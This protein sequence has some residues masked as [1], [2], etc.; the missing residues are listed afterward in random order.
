MNVKE[1]YIRERK[2]IDM[3]ANEVLKKI[4]VA[5]GINVDLEQ[6]KLVDGVTILEA[7]KFEAGAD[8]FIV[9]EEELIP[10]SIGEYEL[11]DG[12]MLV[13][14]QEGIIASVGESPVEEE[15]APVEEVQQGASRLPKKIIE[16]ITQEQHFAEQTPEDAITAVTEAEEMVTEEVVAIISELTPE[17]VNEADASELANDVIQAVTDTLAEMPEEVAM[18]ALSKIKKYGKAKMSDEEAQVVEEAKGMLVDSIA[19]VVDAGTPDDVTPEISAEIA[20][21]IVDAVKEIVGEQPA[22]LSAKLFRREKTQ[23]KKVKNSAVSKRVEMAKQRIDAMKKETKVPARKPIKHN[24]EN[25]Q[26]TE[27]KFK[28]GSKGP[29]TYMDKILKKLF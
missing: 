5:L 4:G 28:Y 16:S 15:E 8:V 26:K 20:E 1:Y 2:T 24:P 11:E 7:D 19:S 27:L 21:T 10:L 13:I 14:E 29:E 18:K 23:A 25:K 9:M 6:I 22:E 12:R 3:K 17:S